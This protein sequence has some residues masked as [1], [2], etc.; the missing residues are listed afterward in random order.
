MTRSFFSCARSNI[1]DLLIAMDLFIFPSKWEGLGITV[2]E[3]QASGLPCILSPALPDLTFCS[4]Y[5]YKMDSPNST[6]G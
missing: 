3:A 4:L 1:P 2:I 5:A 6:S